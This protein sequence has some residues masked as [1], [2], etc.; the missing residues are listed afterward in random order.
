MSASATELFGKEPVIPPVVA[1][2]AEA[3]RP[4][5]SVMIPTYNCSRYLRETLSS[6]LL[7][8]LPPENMQIEVV[9]DCS[10]LDDPQM[11]VNEIGQGRISFYRKPSNGGAT[12]T[13]NACIA[14]SKGKLIHILHGD[15][16]VYPGYY[17][18]I[19]ELASAHPQLGLYATRC[20]F[21]DEESEITGV[22]PRVQLLEQPSKEISP[23]FY[24]TPIQFAGV[25]VRREAYEQLGGFRSDLVHT[26]DCEMWARVISTRGG[27]LLAD[28]LAGYRTFGDND[29]SRLARTA[30]NVRDVQRLN[31]IFSSSYPEF[32]TERG[33][34]RA[35]WTAMYQY[36]KFAR[37]GDKAAASQNW[38]M[39]SELSPFR[40]RFTQQLRRVLGAC[41]RKILNVGWG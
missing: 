3:K 15:D 24:A 6:V 11:V 31:H 32:S 23:F 19:T 41:K 5:W 17:A 28:P 20:F 33:R 4:L 36:R 13:F 1:A 38:R 21:I 40:D 22:T 12:S 8:A 16:R 34:D 18:K 14:R 25:T 30:E 26:A 7:G 37:A 39:W 35:R 9:D 2:S 29:S 27:V 10:T